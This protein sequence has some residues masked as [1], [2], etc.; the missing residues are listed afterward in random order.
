MARK[1]FARIK[2]KNKN[3]KLFKGDRVVY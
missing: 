1:S 3:K 2:N